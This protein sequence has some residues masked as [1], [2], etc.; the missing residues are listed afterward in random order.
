MANLKAVVFPAF[1]LQMFNQT[2]GLYAECMSGETES[3][4]CREQTDYFAPTANKKPTG[5]RF[6]I[7]STCQKLPHMR[8]NSRLRNTTSCSLTSNCAWG[9]KTV[10]DGDKLRQRM[11][12]Y[13]P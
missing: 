8:R 3:G 9:T 6:C 7:G 2:N 1:Y 5:A 11:F 10:E 4:R 13:G 12:S